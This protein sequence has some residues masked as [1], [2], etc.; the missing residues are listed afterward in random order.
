MCAAALGVATLGVAIEAVDGTTAHSSAMDP[1]VHTW[2]GPVTGVAGSYGVS[3]R[4]IPYATQPVGDMRWKNPARPQP[5]TD[6]LP[7][8][9]F[10][11]ACPQQ[12][13]LPPMAC[14]ANISEACL[15]LNVFR[16]FVG[17]DRIDVDVSTEG[18]VAPAPPPAPLLPTLVWIHGGMCAHVCS[19]VL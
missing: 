18:R 4:G 9:A 6:P 7:A 17:A 11:P 14:Q 1:T 15:F 10:G 13:N 8:N 3:W 19:I 12:C 2:D 16:P 5:W